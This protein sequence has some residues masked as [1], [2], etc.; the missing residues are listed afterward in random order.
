MRENE[1]KLLENIS[2]MQKTTEKSGLSVGRSQINSLFQPLQTDSLNEISSEFLENEELYSYLQNNAEHH[3]EFWIRYLVECYAKTQ[4]N[5]YLS[6]LEMAIDSILAGYREARSK[7]GSLPPPS[8]FSPKLIR[9]IYL[10]KN[11]R[12]IDLFSTKL[13][14]PL[15]QST[16]FNNKEEIP[17]RV[18]RHEDDAKKTIHRFLEDG[19]SKKTLDTLTKAS[20]KIQ[21]FTRQRIRRKQVFKCVENLL[22]HHKDYTHLNLSPDELLRDANEPYTPQ[23]KDKALSERIM[24]LV[25][26]INPLF[27]TIK[28]QTNQRHLK[29]ILD[30]ALFG[31]E[32]LLTFYALFS[33]AALFESDVSNGDANVVCFG[34]NEIDSQGGLHTLIIE[35]YLDKVKNLE[36][37]FFKQLD[38][39]F[40]WPGRTEIL[41][42]GDKR[43]KFK[44]LD[45][46]PSYAPEF[47]WNSSAFEL[48][49]EEGKKLDAYAVVPNVSLISYN[50]KKIHQILTL[51]FFRF[52][53]NLRF[54]P[55]EENEEPKKYP[56]KTEEIYAKI[57]A[58]SDEELIDFLERTGKTM[59]QTTEFN[60]YGGHQIDFSAVKSFTTKSWSEPDC[61]YK[62]FSLKLETLVNDLQWGNTKKLSVAEK[63]IPEL[64]TSY[65]FLDYL[66]SKVNNPKV[67]KIL[68]E[69]R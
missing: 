60:F 20:I 22:A 33:P 36:N 31:R 9:A 11:E 64:F 47:N 65:R 45:S 62:T 21:R 48:F 46:M 8:I 39:G 68:Q 14:I 42:L 12:L 57:A 49:N 50:T 52:I 23:C 26:K 38:L 10:S 2:K 28:H 67:L 56:E 18:K 13:P 27:T 55:E 24:R 29:N 15:S 25:E 54:L 41:E 61:A 16:V 30:T 58:L 66:I 51:N 5:S 3:K 53:D 32:N 35:E 34:P 19:E 17:T 63:K 40:R 4:D 69:K 7:G 59:T 1:Q 6:Q 37:C 43:L 44:Y